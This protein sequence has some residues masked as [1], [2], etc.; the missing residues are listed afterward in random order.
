M[1]E[2]TI[3]IFGVSIIISKCSHQSKLKCKVFWTRA[4]YFVA[5]KMWKLA[6]LSGLQAQINLVLLEIFSAAYEI[7][8]SGKVWC[9]YNHRSKSIL[10]N[11]WLCLPLILVIWLQFMFCRDVMLKMLWDYIIQFWST[12]HERTVRCWKWLFYEKNAFLLITIWSW[13]QTLRIHL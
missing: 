3:N 10:D 9:I 8:E 7:R 11:F 13:R 6:K 12:G 5:L 2:W 1:V 4:R